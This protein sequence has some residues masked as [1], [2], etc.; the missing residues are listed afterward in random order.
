M[1]TH[2]NLNRYVKVI[3]V[4]LLLFFP[5]FVNAQ[6][7]EYKFEVLSVKDGLSHNN[8][9]SIIQDKMGYLWIGTQDGLNKY[10]GYKF[11]IYRHEPNN[12][13]S[14][15]T[16]NFGKI[17]QDTSGIFWFGTY[18]GG[19]DVYD[20]KLNRIKNYKNNPDD[21]KSLS[22]NQI[23]F[24]FKDSF[25][26]LWIGTASGG[27]NRYNK[28]D[29][30]FTRFQYNPNNPKGLN[31]T[32]AK[33]ICETEDGTLWVGTGNGL[34]RFNRNTQTFTNYRHDPSN[35]NSLSA[36]N[37]QHLLTDDDGNIWI[38][39]R[40]GGINK[41]NPKTGIFTRYMHDSKNP[42]SIN[43]NKTEFLFID[44]YD[45]FWVGTYEGGL[46][47]FDRKTETFTHFKHDPNVNGSI[48]NNRIE[49]IFEDKSKILWIGT[50]GGG[51]NKLDLKP[52][53]FKNLTYIPNK[54]NSL[55]HPSV[56][57]L[58]IDTN[59]NIWIGTD[60]GGLSRYNQKRNTYK[61]FRHTHTNKNSISSDR[62]WSVLVDTKGVIWA[63]TYEGGLN[64]IEHKNGKYLFS[65]YIHKPKN[66]HSLSCNQI[67]SIIEDKKG[68]IWIAT[69]NGLN[70]I[71]ENKTTGNISFKSFYQNKTDS[72][73]FVDNYIGSIYIDSKNRFWVGSYL[74]GLF[75]F[76]PEK[77]IF[78][79][80]SPEEIDSSQFNR[81][82]HVLIIFED[83]KDNL[84]IG[85]ESNGIIK[86]DLEQ[87]NFS[88]HP[89]NDHL[90]SN[91]IMGMEEDDMGNIWIS[92]S[93]G[94][95]KYTPWNDNLYNYTYT[96]GLISSGFN[97]NALLKDSEGKMYFGSNAGITSFYPLEVSNNPYLPQVVITDFRVLNKSEWTNNLLPYAKILHENKRIELSHKDYFFTIEFAALDF[98]IP[99]ENQYKYKLENFDNEWI[100]ATNSRSATY[101]NLDPGTYVF[102][103]KG[104]NNDKIWNETPTEITIKIIPPFYGTKWFLGI[105]I[106]VV[107]G[108]IALYIQMRTKNLIHDKK[109]LEEKVVAR[110]NKINNQKE[111]L[112]TQA[113]N[114]AQINKELENQ[115]NV[116][117]KL[118]HER[119]TDLEIAKDKAEEA[120]KLKS[121]FLANMS[122]EI[123]TPMNA[124]IGFSNLLDDNDI[125]GKQKRE[126]TTLIVKNSNT[127]LN[128][129]DDIIDI[130]KIETGHVKINTRKYAV[131]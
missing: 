47:L 8:V 88:V 62:V 111:E 46:N 108:L 54:Y 118:V 31:H 92:T 19:I 56:M 72:I 33:C 43:D 69:A 22:N 93:R 41:F 96:D 129:I 21:K 70:K 37:I 120:D 27:L 100:D 14:I 107:I 113:E 52:K 29:D 28:E 4:Y 30:S 42:K 60:G 114:L 51:I 13:N 36:N 1:H 50:R 89:K 73:S 65:N 124:I 101:T 25:D 61:H 122:H 83:N 38:A 59:N 128:L 63:G 117:E 87:N 103:V 11:T 23:S 79:N 20:P 94:L 26:E 75:L 76:N 74:R 12:P 99:P 34:N 131:N 17:Y 71:I 109:S 102:K 115:H 125:E 32:R 16:G 82:I 106:A 84:W 68:N 40:E 44:S 9:Y 5:S 98:T 80:Y 116:L 55:S 77:E 58:D 39:I 91:M 95:S 123:R 2:S 67:N 35:P 15:S 3:L 86:F 130:A 10:D 85:T 64:K 126:L 6:N 97:R 90:L 66:P 104:S 110:T 57:A 78:T 18:G 48:S 112:Q 127:L 49:Y 45:Q 119:T 24:I 105:S 7:F 121:A 81:E 53:K